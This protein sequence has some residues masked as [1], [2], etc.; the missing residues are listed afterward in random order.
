MK[1]LLVSFPFLN[2]LGTSL[3]LSHVKNLVIGN[4]GTRF[5]F[6]KRR[7]LT[8][9]TWELLQ[10]RLGPFPDFLSGAWGQGYF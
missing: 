5:I 6:S 1:N 7:L 10:A 9:H 4:E 8:Q 2:G 3:L